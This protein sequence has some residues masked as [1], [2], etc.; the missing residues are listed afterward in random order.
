[1]RTTGFILYILLFLFPSFIEA[2]DYYWVGGTGNWSNLNHWRTSDNQIPNEV[3]DANDNVI[4]N[5]DSFINPFDTVY[6]LTGNP[7]CHN[8]TWENLV[9]TVVLWGS[10]SIV[11]F[12]IFG[13]VT[14]HPN[15]RNQYSGK[16][17]LLSNET[18]NTISCAG[19]NFRGDLYFE[20]SGEW[21]LQDTLI[22]LDTNA[23]RY[24]IFE[25]NT[26]FGNSFLIK[27]SNG[28]LDLNEH[29]IAAG[30]FITGSNN[31]C[32][33]NIENCHIYLLNSWTLNGEYLN[34]LATGSYI[35]IGKS[36]TNLYGDEI[37]YNDV[38]VK[39]YTGAVTCTGINTIFR[40]LNFLGGGALQGIDGGTVT[41]DTLLFS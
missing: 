1:M 22:V 35:Y 2:E 33:L 15:L 13:S 31:S 3:P 11:S 18:G 19:S 36:M 8:M 27:H 9:D 6:V 37:I 21:I 25:S 4:F 40:K 17:T 5:E 10:T 41:I 16:I 14:L 39:D 7:T 28:K 24:T 20:G 12:D 34:F 30:S 32:E 29:G 26:G 23:W 38:D